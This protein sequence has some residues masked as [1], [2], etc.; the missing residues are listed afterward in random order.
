MAN[1]TF[2]GPVRSENGFVIANKNTTTGSVTDS[3][4]HSSANKDIRRYYLEEY[5]KQRP[6]LNA[7]ATAPLTDADATAAAND[8]IIIARGIASRDFEVLGTSMTT[9]LCTFDTTRAGIIITTAGTDQNQAIIAPHLDTNQSAWQTVL[10]GTEN[11]VI[12][13]CVV[14]TAASIADVKLW[15]GLKLTNDQLIVTDADQAYFKFQTDA[16]NSEAFSDFTLLHFVHSIADTDYIS[17][18][19]IT[20]A[21]DTQ[22]HL[23][24][25]INSDRKA[26]I[27]VNGVQYN[28]T[29]TSGSTGG[30]AVTT[31]T[32]RTAALTN[33]VDLIPYIGV[34]TGAGSAKALKVHAQAISRLIFE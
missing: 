15:S 20:V 21:A 5:W 16:T 25:E 1:T 14:T 26:A 27:Y 11:S 33:D 10:W 8:A 6:A 12:W 31:G 13:E 32:E 2:S 22:Y 18:L 19:P 17:A 34:E 4:L 24:I 3:S 29:T 30:T 9:A 23:K 28:V 7:V